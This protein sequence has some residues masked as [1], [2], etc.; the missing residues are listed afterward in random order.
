MVL[1]ANVHCGAAGRG[2][3]WSCRGACG[4]AASCAL[5]PAAA[6]HLSAEVHCGPAAGG[7][8]V[9]LQRCIVALHAEV[10]YGPAANVALGA[11]SRVYL[12]SC[13]QIC[14]L[15]SCQQKCMWPAEGH[16]DPAAD[17]H[18]VRSRG[19]LWP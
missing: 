10:H 3:L 8:M 9:V 14:A 4:P 6:V 12:W 5:G 19:A 17:V 13:Q 1:P 11:A 16:C 2:A 7:C 15:W 18:V